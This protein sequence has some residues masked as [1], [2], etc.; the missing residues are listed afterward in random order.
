MSEHFLRSLDDIREEQEAI[1]ERELDPDMALVSDYLTGEL[2]EEENSRVRE[3]LHKDPA[4]RDLADPLILAYEHGP[5][6]TPLS[7]VD[8]E[9][10]WLDL[11]RRIGLPD[12]PG[13]RTGPDPQ[14]ERFRAEVHRSD[15][16]TR[17]RRIVVFAASLLM[18][19]GVPVV[20]GVY[21]LFHSND[22]T[23]WGVTQTVDMLGGST[24]TLASGTR[25]LKQLD[26]GTKNRSVVLRGE[27][28][29][30]IVPGSGPPVEVATQSAY[31]DVTGTAFTVH[32]YES[33]PTTVTV[34]RGTVIVQGRD[35][36]LNRI[37]TPLNVTAGQR[38]RVVQGYQPERIP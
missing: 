38:V 32:A 28:T 7:R 21:T 13:A 16:N 6:A 8:L 3:R 30:D 25:L 5:K 27:A 19:I 22:H 31:I 17:T 34:T 14:V 10:K 2:S 35:G 18:V 1:L 37:G 26:F 11:R 4:F 36:A 15:R 20:Y 23:T 24:A 29:F 9:R 33:E 12:L